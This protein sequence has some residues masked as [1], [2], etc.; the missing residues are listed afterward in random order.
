MGGIPENT[1]IPGEQRATSSSSSQYNKENGSVSPVVNGIRGN[2]VKKERNY[3]SEIL[4]LFEERRYDYNDLCEQ[5]ANV[6]EKDFYRLLCVHT[7]HFVAISKESPNLL[8]SIYTFH[9]ES[10]KRLRLSDPDKF[11]RIISRGGTENPKDGWFSDINEDINTYDNFLRAK[12]TAESPSD[13]EK[14]GT[15]DYH[16]SRIIVDDVLDRGEYEQALPLMQELNTYDFCDVLIHNYNVGFFLRMISDDEF[17]SLFS[18]HRTALF[19]LYYKENDAFDEIL[20][21]FIDQLNSP[22]ITKKKGPV[23]VRKALDKVLK[24]KKDWIQLST[25]LQSSIS[26]KILADERDWRPTFL[27]KWLGNEDMDLHDLYNIIEYAKKD[28]QSINERS[29]VQKSCIL[30]AQSFP[31]ITQARERVRI[32]M[33]NADNG[34]EQ[35]DMISSFMKTVCLSVIT[36]GVGSALS[37]GSVVMNIVISG[38]V[39]ATVEGVDQMMTG[40][41]DL[42]NMAQ[43]TGVGLFGG[44]VGEAIA[45]KFVPGPAKKFLIDVVVGTTAS[46]ATDGARGKL[47]LPDE[48]HNYDLDLALYAY[49]MAKIGGIDYD[50]ENKAYYVSKK[51]PGEKGEQQEDIVE[52]INDL[53]EEVGE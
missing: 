42:G 23:F 8:S 40:K 46:I 34:K 51:L 33:K 11:N 39:G 18:K 47:S 1:H 26:N 22:E 48:E 53:L 44:G 41:Y 25:R 35:Y 28:I 2:E 29:D 52:K 37:T 24:A 38:A 31:I 17:V 36:A 45:Y 9:P 21:P 30:F 49:Y 50:Y 5:M 20:G 10:F 13:K 43:G 19:Y 7:N 12:Y 27:I 4:E 15:N 16:D 6:N 32:Y 3:V 14:L